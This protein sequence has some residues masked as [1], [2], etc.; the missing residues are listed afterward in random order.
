MLEKRETDAGESLLA[1]PG[2]FAGCSAGWNVFHRKIEFL[3]EFD[4][5]FC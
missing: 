1:K 3:Q 2:Q 5:I 4:F